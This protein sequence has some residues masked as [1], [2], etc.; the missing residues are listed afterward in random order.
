MHMVKVGTHSLLKH[1][2]GPAYAWYTVFCVIAGVMNIALR[3]ITK[4]ALQNI[5]WEVTNLSLYTT[6]CIQTQVCVV[7]T[8]VLHICSAAVSRGR[9]T[10]NTEWT[11]LYTVPWRVLYGMSFL[12]W[13]HIKAS[14]LAT[15]WCSIAWA[16]TYQSTG[17]TTV[18][19][20]V[21]C[22]F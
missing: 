2:L 21:H 4:L 11:W 20:C 1:P 22:Q 16:S 13:S 8:G 5:S 7:Y 9:Y 10:N 19:R 15:N 17:R 12:L 3:L 18:L 14:P 6:V